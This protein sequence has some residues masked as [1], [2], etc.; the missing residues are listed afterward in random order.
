[1]FRVVILLLTLLGLTRIT[2]AQALPPCVERPTFVDPPQVNGQRWCLEEV[3]HDDSA[4]ELGFT[5]LAAAPD[6][7]LYAAR[8]LVGQ[9]LAL[10]DTNGDGL[11][12]SPRVVADGLTFPNGL[13]YH[14]GALYISGGPHLYRL[15]DGE[16]E[17]LVDDIP[18]GTGFWTGGL[19]VGGDSR[20]Y[21]A[22]GAPCDLCQPD[23]PAR[24]AILSYDLDGGDRRIVATGLR[25]P[26]DVAFLNGVLWTTDTAPDALADIL[27]LDELN[28]VTPGAFFGW[29]YC[30]G[31]NQPTAISAVFDCST[32]TAPALTFP[33]HS[34]PTGLAAYTSGTFADIQDTLLVVLGGSYN[35]A[36]LAGFALAVV[37]FDGAGNPV[38][39]EVIVPEQADKNNPPGQT[40]EILQYRGS[41]LWPHELFDVTANSEGWIFFS[42]GGGRIF[43]LRPL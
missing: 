14:R 7:T 27:N 40:L 19:T 42:V 13:A 39:D 4:G 5:A 38:A 20:L 21:V 6:G 26:G 32:A 43:V 17:T 23:D 35:R 1:M 16:L 36:A 34:T 30:A 28:R 2:Q 31:E 37:H 33:T 12:E 25:Q 11:P 24:G 29:P 22:V 8:P 9:V 3:V 41:G 18:A 10:R 15:R